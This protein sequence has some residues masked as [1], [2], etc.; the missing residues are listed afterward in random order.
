MPLNKKQ[1][2]VNDFF[3]GAG[4]MGL[5]FK[6]AGFNIVGA[7]DFDKY[8]VQSYRVNVGD[9][10]K[11][12][13]IREMV[14]QDVPTA[15][16][17]TFGFPCQDL[18]IANPDGDGLDGKRSGLFFQVMRL[19]EETQHN[20]PKAL[21]KV[22]MAENVVGL[23]PYLPVLER[24]Y[25]RNGYKALYTKLNSKYFGVPQSRERYFVIGIRADLDHT[26]FNFPYQSGVDSGM[27]IKHILQD[28]S[29]IDSKFYLSDKAIEYMSRERKGKP[30]WEYHKNEVDGI[31]ATLTANMWKGVPYGVIQ[32]L[33]RYR[34]FTP[35]EC[36]RLQGFPDSY[37]QV[38]SDTQFYKQMGNGVTVTVA[39]ALA[40]EIKW[41][42]GEVK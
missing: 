9:H 39:N 41:F 23:R 25:G 12:S 28:D 30:R 31:A 42:L 26:L 21:P 1:F 20:N 2:R 36:A 15:D 16:V 33:P 13:D 24:E 18:S 19:L 6:Q 35:R 8:A 27:R 3:C 29:E 5:G 40:K 17:W 4:G 34:R 11:Q 10:V 22:V 38:V 7:W 14:W 32:G 37:M